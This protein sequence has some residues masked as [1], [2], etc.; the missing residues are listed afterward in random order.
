M[1]SPPGGVTA[2]R[3]RRSVVGEGWRFLTAAQSLSRYE[4]GSE[5]RI[6]E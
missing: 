2:S 5:L 1:G 4:G 6:V 3:R